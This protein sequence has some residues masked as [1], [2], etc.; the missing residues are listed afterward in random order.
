MISDAIRGALSTEH[1]RNDIWKSDFMSK[2]FWNNPTAYHATAIFY[3]E[4][5][6]GTI[7]DP[8]RNKYHSSDVVNMHVSLG[9]L[10]HLYEIAI[11]P[12]NIV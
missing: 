1:T 11:E 7:S 2:K 9:F 8:G 12:L 6:C 3:D 10:H 5:G 4:K